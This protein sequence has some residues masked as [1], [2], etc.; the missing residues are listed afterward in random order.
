MS[1]LVK[2]AVVNEMLLP[3]KWYAEKNDDDDEY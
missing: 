2:Y 3:S 1:L